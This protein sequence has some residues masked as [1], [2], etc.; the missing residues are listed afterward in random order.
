MTRIWRQLIFHILKDSTARLT[1]STAETVLE[2]KLYRHDPQRVLRHGPSNTAVMSFVAQTYVSE[3][4]ERR[5][6]LQGRTYLFPTDCTLPY[7]S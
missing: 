3:V 7:S 1:R 5:G 6:N 2:N 4:L